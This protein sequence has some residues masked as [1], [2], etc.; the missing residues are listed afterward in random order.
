MH[1]DK[2]G[3]MPSDLA[4]VFER[5]SLNDESWLKLI[6]DFRRKF[7]RAAGKPESLTKEAQKHGCQKMPGISH[8][9]AIFGP[10]PLQSTA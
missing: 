5:L 10:A 1:P 9:R 2:R 4:P 7:S 3:A 8:S 6:Q